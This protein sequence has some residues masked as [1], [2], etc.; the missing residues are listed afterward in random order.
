M[1][2]ILVNRKDRFGYFIHAHSEG[3]NAK[4]ERWCY[5]VAVVVIELVFAFR[6]SRCAPYVRSPL[7]GGQ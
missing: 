7:V 5:V 6:I 4:R 2:Y 1:V 3:A